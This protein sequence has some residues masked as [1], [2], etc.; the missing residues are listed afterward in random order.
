MFL[1]SHRTSREGPLPLG[2]EYTYTGGRGVPA[3]KATCGQADRGPRSSGSPG[4]RT[5][6]EGWRSVTELLRTRTPDS[7]Q[8]QPRQAQVF[9]EICGPRAL[10]SAPNQVVQDVLRKNLI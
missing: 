1:L 4:L 9:L 3:E 8:V 2:Y 6:L 10:C 5:S 7:L